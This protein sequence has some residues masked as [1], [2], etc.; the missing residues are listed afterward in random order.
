MVKDAR[1]SA[2][3]TRSLGLPLLGESKR[4]ALK[5]A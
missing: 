1:G 2:L 4:G 3:L 5:K